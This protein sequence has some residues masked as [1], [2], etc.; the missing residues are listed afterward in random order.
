MQVP[1]WP[2]S[3]AMLNAAGLARLAVTTGL[4]LALQVNAALHALRIRPAGAPHPEEAGW[5]MRLTGGWNNQISSSTQS[6]TQLR[7]LL[8]ALSA[9]AVPDFREG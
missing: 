3:L 4:S 6:S 7:P 1:W 5:E 2:S 9:G 8:P